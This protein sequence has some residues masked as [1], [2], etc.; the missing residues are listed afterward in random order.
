MQEYR[1]KDQVSWFTD[2]LCISDAYGWCP[3]GNSEWDVGTFNRGHH[4]GYI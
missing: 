3:L 2:W 1:V 4:S